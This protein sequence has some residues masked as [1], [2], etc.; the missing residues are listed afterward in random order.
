[1]IS[2]RVCRGPINSG[3]NI[4]KKLNKNISFSKIFEIKIYQTLKNQ[5]QVNKFKIVGLTDLN[6][7]T[8]L[9]K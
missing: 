8:K 1:M 6:I 9:I 4:Q 5:N 3:H 7:V 2:I